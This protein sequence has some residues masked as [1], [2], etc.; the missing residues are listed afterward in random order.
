MSASAIVPVLP[1]GLPEEWVQG[2]DVSCPSCQYNLRGLHLPRCPECGLIFRWQALLR[3][4]CPRCGERLFT[5]DGAECPACRLGLNWLALLD[6]AAAVD[7]RLYEY[8]DQPVRGALR[9]WVMA[10]RPYRFWRCVPLELPPVHGRLGRLRW[11]AFSSPLL[12]LLLLVLASW[13]SF[14][15]AGFIYLPV[16]LVPLF[17]LPT[18]TAM[19]LPMFTPTLAR[20][21]IRRDQLRR[22]FVYST[23]G[24][25]WVGACSAL[26]ALYL[27]TVNFFWPVSTTLWG[28]PALVPRLW[29]DPFVLLNMLADP[30]EPVRLSHPH[31]CW[32]NTVLS[33]VVLVLASVWWWVFLYAGLRRYLRLDAF[34]AIALL[35]STQLI[36]LLILGALVAFVGWIEGLMY[37]V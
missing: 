8:T 12:G 32:F 19:G 10:L 22:V 18:T 5:N 29:F 35:V 36:G 37:G 14:G 4:I 2:R 7:R 3:V 17:A 30:D 11:V 31:L 15:A 33:A 23:S 21:Q 1:A 27:A 25:F 9:T 28:T 26:G 20:L 16:L 6:E 13:G 24:L 34:N